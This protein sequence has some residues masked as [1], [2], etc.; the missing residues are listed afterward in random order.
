MLDDVVLKSVDHYIGKD[1]QGFVGKPAV[2][3][4]EGVTIKNI[5][6]D[7]LVDV[8]DSD[9]NISEGW[10]PSAVGVSIEKREF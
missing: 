2:V 8:V 9:G 1:R 3:R 7:G 10:A 5:R 4:G 6:P